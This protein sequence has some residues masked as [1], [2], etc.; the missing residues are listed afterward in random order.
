MFFRT[1][2]VLAVLAILVLAACAAIDHPGPQPVETTWTP[3]VDNP[4]YATGEGPRI[5]VDAAH[6]NWHTVDGRFAPFADLLRADGYRVSGSSEPITAETLAECDVL[7]IANA[8][9]GGE[10]SVWTL[11]T[12][13]ALSEEEAELVITWVDGG[14]SLLLI[15][16]HMPFPASVERLAHAFGFTFYNGYAKP[17]F[18]ESGTLVFTRENGLLAAHP[19]FQARSGSGAITRIKSF[20]G[21]AFA[22]PDEADV[23]MRMPENWSVFLPVDAFQPF[24][25]QTARISA[26][27]LAQGALLSHG[28]GRV[29]V[30]GE[31]G[32]F[33]A[34]SLRLADGQIYHLGFA[35][36]DAHQNAA[37]VR[38]V[39]A[40]LSGSS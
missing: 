16:D 36:P 24:T 14:G 18:D 2:Q 30:F 22:A 26:R 38:N 23:L 33:T 21:Q 15:A 12:P 39:V 19:V 29:A 9:L 6:G 4:A 20:S 3:A 11:P 5:V 31:A 7:V 17:A 10:N 34:Q 40:W 37:F 8:V 35:D 13:P 28:S 25:S 1:K 27:G 32:M